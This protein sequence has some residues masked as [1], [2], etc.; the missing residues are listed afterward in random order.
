MANLV[1]TAKSQCPNDK[2]VVSG[3]S[4]GAMVVH[5]AF[6]QGISASDVAGA[7]MFGDPLKTQSISGLSTEKVKEFC[8]TSDSICGTGDNPQGSH[9][10]APPGRT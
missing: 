5:N 3:Y 4:Q 9:I 8:A 10:S 1:K 6:K 2:I 7:L